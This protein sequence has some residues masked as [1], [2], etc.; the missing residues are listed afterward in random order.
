MQRNPLKEYREGIRRRRPGG[1]TETPM[2]QVI[3]LD[4]GSATSA[5]QV[6]NW[7]SADSWLTIG[8]GRR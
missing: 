1:S 8:K 4:G 2:A 3:I 6:P 5:S 7:Q